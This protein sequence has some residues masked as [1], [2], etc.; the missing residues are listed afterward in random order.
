MVPALAV[1]RMLFSHRVSSRPVPSRP[2]TSRLVSRLPCYLYE[3]EEGK[4]AVAAVRRFIRLD[5]QV[6]A[7]DV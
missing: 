7:C 4:V 1:I 3:V 2:V 6:C 5:S